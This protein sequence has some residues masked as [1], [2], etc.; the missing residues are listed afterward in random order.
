MTE[1]YSHVCKLLIVHLRKKGLVVPIEAVLL[2]EGM[3]AV[4]AAVLTEPLLQT[5]ALEVVLI[6]FQQFLVTA[7]SHSQ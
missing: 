4:K 7:T 5:L 2:A 1:A 3:H 6:V